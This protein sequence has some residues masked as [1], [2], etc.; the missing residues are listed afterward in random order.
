MTDLDKL[1]Y[2][3]GMKFTQT[4]AG[5]L[6]HQ[7]KYAMDLLQKFNLIS[8]N[9]MANLIEVNVKLTKDEGGKA[10]DETLYKQIVGSL[11]FLCNSRPD[12]SY[13]VGL[14]SSFMCSPKESHMQAVKKVLSYVQ[15]TSD[16]GVLFQVGRQ[17]SELEVI[18]FVDAGYDGDL[19]E[20]KSTFG[21]L[22]LLNNAPISWYSKKQLMIALFSC[23][24]EFI[25]RSY[26][27]CQV[28]W[29]E[30]LLKEMRI[31]VKT[32]LQLTLTTFQQ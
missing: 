2:F 5:L 30:E 32:P 28:V 16:C 12:L 6:M 18:R 29:L 10:M 31:S 11:R 4:S 14:V 1:R 21:Y 19:V 22:F 27:T 7:K 26:A 20:R 24:V 3:L 15:G 9:S 23:E 8:C 17:K 25:S 13:S